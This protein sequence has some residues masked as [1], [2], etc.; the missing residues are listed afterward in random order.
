MKQLI[1]LLVAFPVV[2]L[3]QGVPGCELTGNTTDMAFVERLKAS[4]KDE[5]FN[6]V[7]ALLGER[8]ERV[9]RGAYSDLQVVRDV[10]YLVRGANVGEPVYVRW[11][12][13]TPKSFFAHAA[14]GQYH[15]NVGSAKRGTE[16]IS[17]VSDE[18]LAGMR[19]AFEKA[20]VHFEAASSVHPES[21][22]PRF[23]LIAIAALAEGAPRLHQLVRDAETADPSTMAARVLALEYFVPR[24]GVPFA[25]QDELIERARKSGFDDGKLRYLNYVRQVNRAEH[26]QDIDKD[27]QKALDLYQRAADACPSERAWTG[28]ARTAWHTANWARAKDA[29]THS[30]AVEPRSAGVLVIR[31]SA[32][33]KLNLHREAALDYKSAAELGH[34]Y[35]QMRYGMYLVDGNGPWPTDLA[36]AKRWLEAAVASGEKRAAAYVDGI[37]KRLATR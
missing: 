8:L 23:G 3:A 11:V 12:A 10:A 7:D 35:A 37:N 15:Y 29:A 33:E 14:K 25:A 22:V 18:Q 34:A 1:P 30:L 26:Y 27:A 6:E 31:A 28:V 24:W 19:A 13:A 21:A 17:K 9:R 5:K 32:S 16:F 4:L 20:K 36:Q 2:V